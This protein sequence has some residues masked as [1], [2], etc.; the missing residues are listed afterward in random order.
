MRSALIDSNGHVF[1]VVLVDPGIELELGP[2]V[3]QLPL[4]DDSLVGPGWTWDGENYHEPVVVELVANRYEIP[5][6]GSTAALV[7]YRN[8]GPDAPGMVTFSANGSVHTVTMSGTEALL[9]ITSSTPGD[10]IT[11]TVDALP[12]AELTIRVV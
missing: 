6:D 5:G 9:E 4:E 12:G 3:L 1:N 11:V 10:W 8:T 7:A 2:D